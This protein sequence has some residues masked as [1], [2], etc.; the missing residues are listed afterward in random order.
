MASLPAHMDTPPCP[1]CRA[2]TVKPFYEER[3]PE[4]EMCL[5]CCCCGR[6][7]MDDDPAT[8]ER[9]WKAQAAWERFSA[10]ADRLASQV[11]TRPT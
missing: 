5:K 11:K 1:S 7:W 9:A 8:V 4:T 10:E 3:A 2:N 6:Y